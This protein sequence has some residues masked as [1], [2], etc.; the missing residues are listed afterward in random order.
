LYGIKKGPTKIGPSI[1]GMEFF[2]A[3]ILRAHGNYG[4]NP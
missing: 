1:I 3:S 2:K 4:I